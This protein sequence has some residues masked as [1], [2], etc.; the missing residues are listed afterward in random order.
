MA[1]ERISLISEEER[2]TIT[3]EQQI[4]TGEMN[5]EV[6]STLSQEEQT[7]VNGILFKM[8]SEKVEPNQGTSALEF[9]LFG[10]MRIMNKKITGLALSEDEK[11][12]D[13]SLNRIM[14]LHQ[15]TNEEV[16]KINW[17]FDYMGYAEMKSAEFLQ[18]RKEHIER[19]AQITGN[20]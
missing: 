12:I 7:K 4:R 15:I 10:F 2:S 9:I 11:A 20:I 3:L 1:R 19:K 13:E 14:N 18:N 17:L 5:P 6:F 16:L 8:A